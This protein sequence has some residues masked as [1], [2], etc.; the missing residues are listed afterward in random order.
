MAILSRLIKYLSRSRS[1]IGPN[2][3]DTLANP[4]SDDNIPTEK[5]IRS[6]LATAAGSLAVQAEGVAVG[7]HPTLN[8]IEGDNAVLSVEDNSAA[9]RIDVT[10]SA[11][12]PDFGVEMRK[13]NVS[14]ATRNIINLMEGD[15]V[16]LTVTDSAGRVDVEIAAD[17]GGDT[18]STP[19]RLLRA[20]DA[21]GEIIGATQVLVDDSG[22]MTNVA[23]LTI[24]AAARAVP[25]QLTS[26]AT[27]T[28]DFAVACD[29]Y[30]YLGHEATLAN[31]AN[32]AAG[33]AG[34]I[35]IKMNGASR[36]LAYESLWDFVG[37]TAPECSTTNGTTDM[38]YYKT[39]IDPADGTTV[40]IMAKMDKAVA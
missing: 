15:N 6:A 9:A 21:N 20:V 24:K 1:E 19:N 37:G 33:Q 22:S 35:A 17:V 32:L 23:M 30:L 27:I 12:V 5:A 29:F 28:P 40:R 8:F 2:V 26:G 31:P 10:I 13:D 11:S 39:Y 3:V 14:V 25:A 7:T 18:G 34:M 36:T 38:L 16:D 4:G